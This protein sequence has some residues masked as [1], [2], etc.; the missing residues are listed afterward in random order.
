MYAYM[1]LAAHVH[2]CMYANAVEMQCMTPDRNNV[3]W[4]VLIVE[5]PKILCNIN[6]LAVYLYDKAF[7]GHL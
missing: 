7:A 2:V 1:I 5:Y 3:V 6:I 4:S